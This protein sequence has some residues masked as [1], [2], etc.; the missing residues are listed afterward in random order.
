[1]NLVISKLVIVILMFGLS[2]IFGFSY[3]FVLRKFR[4]KNISFRAHKNI[5]TPDRVVRFALGIIL[6]F[7]GLYS[8][9]PIALFWSG[10]C[11]YEGIA[12]WCGFYAVI[13]R[14]T[15]SIN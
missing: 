14:N 13:G 9:S 15:C 1:M 8:W 2:F 12:N 7:I 4:A 6:L 3:Q 5:G 10:F 11:F